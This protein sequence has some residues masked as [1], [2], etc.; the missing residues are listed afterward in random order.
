MFWSKRPAPKLHTEYKAA[1]AN[2]KTFTLTLTRYAQVF[3][4]ETVS[5]TMHLLP[6]E[7]MT[8]DVA[9]QYCDAPGWTV[10]TADN[11]ILATVISTL[12]G[13]VP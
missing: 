5:G 6:G 12:T 7:M 4:V 10:T 13:M 9:Q 2:G 8:L 1:P 11:Q 3:K